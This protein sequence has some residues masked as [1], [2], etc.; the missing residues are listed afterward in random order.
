MRVDPAPALRIEGIRTHRQAAFPVQEICSWRRNPEYD[1]RVEYETKFEDDP[2][3]TWEPEES[4][5]GGVEEILAEFKE[6]DKEL[7][8]TL[9]G[10]MMPSTGGKQRRSTRKRKR[11]VYVME[12][13]DDAVLFSDE[14]VYLYGESDLEEEVM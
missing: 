8:K 13:D 5:K 12:V 14:D 6:R 1:G 9:S 3:L 7:Q 4:F 11:A 10:I 2:E